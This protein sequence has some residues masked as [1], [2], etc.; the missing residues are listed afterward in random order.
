[1]A[2]NEILIQKIRSIGLKEKA[3]II[4]A[5]LLDLGGAYPARI[6]AITKMN[7]ST[8]YV[9]LQELVERSLVESMEKGK[10]MYFQIRQAESVIAYAESQV[11][12]ANDRMKQAQTILPELQGLISLSPNKPKVRFF[13]GV[14]GCLELYSDHINVSEG[15]EMLA[16]SNAAA[17][18][19]MVPTSY[20]KKYV[21]IKEK[22]GI[23]TR[24]IVPGTKRSREYNKVSYHKWGVNNTIV[25][26]IRFIPPEMYPYKSEITLYACNKLSIVNFKSEAAIGVIIEDKDLHDTMKAIFELSWLGTAK[27]VD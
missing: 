27:F 11:R 4:Y 24:A 7:R 19:D 1:M 22:F 16:W 26:N 15:Y 21:K 10:K 9:I 23:I 3:A 2:I 5:T 12:K 18:L 17:F 14:K 8:V 25:P 20:H 6:S 13:D